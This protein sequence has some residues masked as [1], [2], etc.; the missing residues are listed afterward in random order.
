LNI[1]SMFKNRGGTPKSEISSGGRVRYRSSDA[2]V[3]FASR[4]AGSPRSPEARLADQYPIQRRRIAAAVV[5]AGAA[6]LSGCADNGQNAL[7]A[8]SPQSHDIA[9]L[10]WWMLGVASLVFLGAVVM[11]IVGWL[12]RRDRGLPLVGEDE[13]ANERLVVAFGIAIPVVI[14]ITLFLVANVAVIGATAAPKPSS[15]RLTIQ[16]VGHDW[17]WEVRYPGH[18]AV[19]ANEIHIP[20]GTRVDVLGTTDDVIH[21]LWVPELNR[22]ID[23]IPGRVNRVLLYADHAGTYRGQ[24]AEFCGLQHAHMSFLVYADPPA[25]F[26]AWLAAE[27]KPAAAPSGSLAQHGRQVFLSAPCADCHQIR[28]T[29]ADAQVG[30][31]LTHLASRSTLAAATVPNGPTDLAEWIADP[32]HVKPGN[33]MPAVRLD[34]GELHAIVAYLRSLH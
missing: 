13:T 9:V 33:L 12:R 15:T 8:Q 28:G 20:T 11:L 19:T 5:A 21:S 17:W 22:K 23:L 16:V 14:L 29:S 3:V 2:A 32:Q 27:R 30:P 10:W 18:V 1:R 24:C 26:R 31:D 4:G 6:T 34:P 7:H 25:R